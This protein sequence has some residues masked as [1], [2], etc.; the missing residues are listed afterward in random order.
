MITNLNTKLC[1]KINFIE[2]ISLDL[3]DCTCPICLDVL[4]EPISTPC[5]HELCLACFKSIKTSPTHFECPL[6]RR[7]CGEWA[8]R[9]E[10]DDSSAV[11][12]K[13]WQEIQVAFAYEIRMKCEGK[14]SQIVMDAMHAY[15]LSLLNPDAAK[16]PDGALAKPGELHQEYLDLV[17]KEQEKL[18]RQREIEEK[19][20]LELIKRLLVRLL[21]MSFRRGP[22]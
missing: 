8:R 15:R 6:C 11:D 4:V 16:R 17:Q 10:A 2:K 22:F 21:S 5:R 7:A 3:N 9:I 13:R 18:K 19:E 20:S 12:R 14:S 1:L